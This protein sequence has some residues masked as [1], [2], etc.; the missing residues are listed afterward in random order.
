MLK[1]YDTIN[2]ESI[3]QKNGDLEISVGDILQDNK[4]ERR[5][6]IVRLDKY[7]VG[8]LREDDSYVVSQVQ[9]E[10]GEITVP[11]LLDL[12]RQVIEMPVTATRQDLLD[13]FVT[14]WDALKDI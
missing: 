3:H 6:K 14:N 10:H 5:F 9:T 7:Y 12:V 11:V 8:L 2:G 13:E 1:D 4:Q